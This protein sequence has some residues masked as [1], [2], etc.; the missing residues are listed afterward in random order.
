MVTCKA[1]RGS[2]KA[3]AAIVGFVA[4]DGSEFLLMLGA[5]LVAALRYP[6][7]LFGRVFDREHGQSGLAD[8]AF[9]LAC[10]HEEPEADRG[11]NC[12]LIAA[13][14]AGQNEWI[15]EDKPSTRCQQAR[16]VGEHAAAVGQVVDRIDAENSI[17]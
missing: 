7:L 8:Q 4:F 16:P 11:S 9:V 3:L 17:E 12:D 1:C 6:R 10:G 14:W 15:G 2:E 13:D 5:G